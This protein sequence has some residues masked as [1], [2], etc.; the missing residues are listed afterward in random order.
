M[1]R[2]GV[3][4]MTFRRITMK[5]TKYGC[6]AAYILFAMAWWSY[7]VVLLGAFLSCG[8]IGEGWKSESEQCAGNRVLMVGRVGAISTVVM[9]VLATLMPAILLWNTPM[10]KW[11]RWQMV[12]LLA[13]GVM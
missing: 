11:K 8:P 5:M 10:N 2:F 12:G 13:F 3:N 1:L 7:A 6:I 4:S 9:D